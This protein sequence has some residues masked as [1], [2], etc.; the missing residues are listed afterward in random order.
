V[1]V[2]LAAE[3][4]KLLDTLSLRLAT[5]RMPRVTARELRRYRQLYQVYPR[6][7]ESVTPKSSS[8]AVAKALP[9][10]SDFLPIPIRE[11]LTAESPIKETVSPELIHRLSFTHLSELIQLTDDTQR[12]FYARARGE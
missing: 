6:I 8:D 10:L 11:S 9:P 3:G 2:T 12:H 1:P 7:R 4:E 5:L